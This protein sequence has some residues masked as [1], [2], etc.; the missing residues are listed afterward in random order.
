MP[1]VWEGLVDWHPKASERRNTLV[2]LVVRGERTPWGLVVR[3]GRRRVPLLPGCPVQTRGQLR[4][5]P[6]HPQALASVAMAGCPLQMVLRQ[7]VAM[8]EEA[9]VPV[10]TTLHESAARVRGVK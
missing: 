4:R 7:P 10:K 8:V 5:L 9:G 3:G 2:A 1:V 6:L